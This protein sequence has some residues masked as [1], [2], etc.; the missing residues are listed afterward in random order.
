MNTTLFYWMLIL[1]MVAWMAVKIGRSS[2]VMGVV[3]FLFWPIAIVPLIT[4]WGQRDSDIRLQFFVVALASGLLWKNVIEVAEAERRMRADQI[5]MV[6]EDDAIYAMQ[7]EA[8][9][10]DIGD[11]ASATSIPETEAPEQ[12]IAPVPAKV[13]STPLHEIRF[14]RGVVRLRH[15]FANLEVPPH[16]RFIGQHQLGLLSEQRMVP[17]DAHTLGWI[18]HER[19]N[20]NS[21]DFWFIEVSFHEVGHLAPP[22]PG[23]AP[24]P[25]QWDAP[26]ATAIWG[27]PAARS[28][29][30]IDHMAVK[31][32]RHGAILFRVPELQEGQRELG[33]RAV[34]LMAA[35]T[36]PE[37]GW[38]YAE[39]IGDVSTQTLAQW[40][41]S[42]RSST[43]PT[44]VVERDDDQTQL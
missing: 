41:E 5:T 21:P 30:G 39:Y 16:F 24:V 27:Q 31:L 19:V 35:R 17:V 3:T 42:L 32:T 1:V 15:A 25:M 26:S 28:E 11:A 12:R 20:L 8:T 37:R 29:R 18:V 22:S 34:R 38:A 2:V 9:R 14:Q 10:A 43:E 6:A 36:E 23:S 33:M 40:A 7:I 4:N 13:H 44:V